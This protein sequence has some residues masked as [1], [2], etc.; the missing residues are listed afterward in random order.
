[1]ATLLLSALAS[2]QETNWPRFRGPG[3]SGISDA[4][5]IPVT[6]TDKD[7]NWKVT[8]PGT[9][10]SSPVIWGK[11]IYI[12]CG[13]A[14]ATR[15]VIC[16]DAATGAKL[17][18]RDYPSKKFG[19]H[20]DNSYASATPAADADG[21][22]VTWTT[23]EEVTVVAISA[24]GN[25]TWRRDMGGFVGMHGSG[26]SPVI[27]N[28]VVVL[29]NDQEDPNALPPAVYAKTG[30]KTAGKS[31][32]WGFDRATGKTRYEIPRRSTQAA[33]STP[34]LYQG[35]GGKAEMIFS[36][37]AQGVTSI[38]PA[39]G[40]INWELSAF[41]ERCVGSPVSAPGLVFAGHGR[42][43]AGVSIVAIKPPV[44]KSGKPEL[45]YEIKKPVPLVISP[46]VKD[47]RLFLWGDDGSV[48]CLNSATGEKLWRERVGGSFYGSPVCVNNRLY[49]IARSGDVVV[50]SAGDKYE[51][52]AR[53]PLGEPAFTTPA[54]ANGV[55]YL[56]TRTQLFSLGGRKIEKP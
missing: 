46:L 52:L 54:M 37:T 21:V 31:T 51:L 12:T 22:V 40:T 28:D 47:G 10:N 39:T 23:P 16:L 3:G 53:V 18:Q 13:D 32:I 30:I 14:N 6:W 17:W 45:A 24:D 19:Q 49:C 8:L 50:I 11:R 4:A 29:A 55:M 34:C 48:A 38:D 20:G 43:S 36:T 35:A 26:S 27:Y 9:G 2:A 7:Y 41:N 56:R 15:M 42:G 33:Y 5:T 25:E 44:D 1:M